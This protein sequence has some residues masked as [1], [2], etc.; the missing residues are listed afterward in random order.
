MKTA[1]TLLLAASACVAGI[2]FADG[3]RLDTTA[4]GAQ[5]VVF[6]AGVF[7]PGGVDSN[8]VVRAKARFDAGLTKV[9]VDV[10]ISNLVGTFAAAHFHCGRPGENGPVAFGLINPGPLFLDGN[11]IRGTLDNSHFN[12]ADCSDT[13]G[14]PV[15]NIAALAFA[16]DKGLIYLNIHSTV[17]PAGE[18]RGQLSEAD[19]D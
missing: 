17:F 7:V 16:M 9:E 3:P 12:G 15:N 13:V 2:A 4:T 10:R 8:A 18:A 1:K 19:K 11:R 5:E 6:D 14:R